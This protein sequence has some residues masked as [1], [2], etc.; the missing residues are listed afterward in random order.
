VKN[1]QNIT[2]QQKSFLLGLSARNN[3][4]KALSDQFLTCRYFSTATRALK[5][6]EDLE[7]KSTDHA[8][9]KYGYCL[10]ASR[11]GT[12]EWIEKSD[13]IWRWVRAESDVSVDSE[14][15]K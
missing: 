1:K 12:T 11:R 9:E 6:S 10:L 14:N 2:D 7:H 5:E 3:L 15:L 13:L 8:A 4:H